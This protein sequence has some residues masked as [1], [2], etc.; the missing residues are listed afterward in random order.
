MV[1][2]NGVK[3]AAGGLR[4]SE[5]AISGAV[6]DLNGN[7]ETGSDGFLRD[8]ALTGTLG[9][10]TTPD[11]VLLPV[12]GGKTTLQSAALNVR[13][14][15][16]TRWN[17]LVVLDRLNA[18]DIE[19]E[20]V[21]LRLGGLAQN[22]EDPA[23][24]TVTV[25]VEGL[26]TGVWSADPKV[27]QALGTRIDLFA[28]AALPPNAPIRVNQLQ[29]SGNGLSIFSA[30]SFAQGTYTG[31]NAVRISDIAVFAGLADRPLSGAV[32]LKA[33]GSVTPLSGGFDLTFDG[34]VTDI[35]IGDA[36]ADALLAGATTISGRAVR[37]EAGVR[38]ENLRIDN[39]Q[40]TFASN[41]AISS[42]RTDIGFDAA[43]A[44]LALVDPRLA[45]RATASGRAT[46]NGRPIAVT[47]AAAIP[48]GRVMDRALTNA[49]LG[50]TGQVD[51]TDVTGTLDGAGGLDGLVL[52]LGGDITV[53]GERRAISGLDVRVG[54]NHLTGDVAKDGTAP[55]TGTLRLDAPDI[56]PLA[57]LALVEATGSVDATVELSAATVGQ[58]VDLT[59]QAR[60][61][62]VGATRVGSL[63]ANAQVNDALGLP[64]VN[65]TLD[66]GNLVVGGIEIASIGATATQTDATAMQFQAQSRLAIGTL[67]N[68]SGEL[69]RL[70]DGFAA[71]LDTLRLRQ[72]GVAATL[73]APATVTISGGAVD[74]T[75]VRLDFGTGSLTA[76]GR[77]DEAFDIDVNIVTMPLA[78]AN[79][80]Q[81]SL[82]LAGSINGTAR[83]T[84][85]RNAPD[86]RFDLAANGVESA[87][88]RNAG[89]PPVALTAR[90]TT[91]DGRL[92]LDTRVTAGGGLA[93]EARGSVPLGATGAL[94]LRV[95]LQSFP[96][97]LV[98]RIAGNRGLRGTV[99]GQA[100][101]RGTPAD[102]DVTFN[103][104]GQGLTAN[105][106]A[107]N[108]IPAVDATADG[109][110]RARTVTLTTVRATG[111]GGMDLTASGRIP[112]AG[113]G[114]DIQVAGTAPLSIANPF[115]EQRSA[116]AAG[117]ARINATARGSL[118]APQLGGTVSIAGG[119]FVDPQVNLRLNGI[120]LEA[121]LEG[122]A[123]VLRSFSAEVASGGR[124]T[125]DGRVTLNAAAGYPAQ[126]TGRILDVRYTDGA[127]ITTRLSGE[128]SV[129]GPLVGGA[130]LLAGQID[131]GRT[132]ISIAEGL[133]GQAPG[134]ARAGRP[135]QHAAPRAGHPR[136]RPGRRDARGER[137]LGP[138]GHAPRR[139]DQRAE[140][141]LR[142]RPR[143]RR[144]A[145]RLGA[146][147]GP[148]HRP[149]ARRP[150]RPAPRPPVDPRPAHRLRRGLAAAR[151]Q[152]RPADPL[153]RAHRVDRRHRHR[154][155]QR[156]G[157]VARDR[158]LLRAGAAPGRG[159]GPHPFQPHHREP[160]ALP[161]RPARRRRG[162]AR[163]GRRPR[164]HVADPRRHRA[165]RPRHRHRGGRRHRRARRQVPR[166]EPLRERPDRHRRPDPGRDQPRRQRPRHRPRRGRLR[167]QH[168]D[169][170]LLRARLLTR[171]PRPARRPSRA[172]AASGGSYSTLLVRQSAAHALRGLF[173]PRVSA[174]E[175]PCPSPGRRSRGTVGLRISAV[176][177]IRMRPPPEGGRIR[178]RGAATPGFGAGR[179]C[180]TPLRLRAR[181]LQRTARP[182]QCLGSSGRGLAR[183]R[184]RFD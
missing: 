54:P 77:M 148:H 69:K 86:V 100:T 131:L 165:R 68:L 123:A 114:L 29:I 67:A 14:G 94:D 22:L 37:D 104:R 92:A 146:H 65:G 132:E 181:A 175:R 70:D 164:D 82:A 32:D 89:L 140:P 60:D 152:P 124:I 159:A 96:V 80:V 17:G 162:R 129:D 102:P 20:D 72:Q 112:L 142:A 13:F 113:P 63:D 147:P 130:G 55:A 110:F 35:T 2:V 176:D 43:L 27:A 75:P 46:G 91:S 25:S 98:D 79:T 1:R 143:P 145:R 84:G 26:A 76:Q 38:T 173:G 167:R 47:L 5:L 33:N 50:F 172:R 88:T 97:A 58:G 78:I 15:Q 144:R 73:S 51:G 117:V 128:L 19:M 139:P 101:V 107:T 31:R 8:L 153:R 57:A 125:A 95:D 48:D 149:P 4:I 127:F 87:I 126:L 81:P 66:A 154:H 24:R 61:V 40:L 105:V 106:L 11:A 161:A 83:I 178:V 64:L 71:R 52:D 103:L 10:P 158:L 42:T 156:P 59:A 171:G 49:R 136:P 163:R 44:D 155:R 169:R 3:K 177:E 135:H 183:Q 121:S 179:D 30:G 120:A 133:G 12:P 99:T 116:Q 174:C 118:A 141:D 6:L 62:I 184:A 16:G 23:T 53:A 119:T 157:L 151:R 150:V 108:G 36:R 74:L 170:H 122:N 160:V 45:G 138:P 85:P 134:R 180:R 18:A 9:D 182:R 90:G 109:T 115:L 93:A 34:G 166:R 28:D 111:A 39:Q 137:H 7:L 41:G 168:H 21:T 56:A